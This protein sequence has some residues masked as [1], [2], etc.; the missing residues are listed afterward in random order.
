MLSTD[1]V[2][3]ALTAIGVVVAS[4][5]AYFTFRARPARRELHVVGNFTRVSEPGNGAMGHFELARDLSAANPYSITVRVLNPKAAITS[6]MYDGTV[7][8]KVS[9]HARV[10][11]FE[12]R[13]PTAGVTR[14]TVQIGS[15]D[16][17]LELG[18]GPIRAWQ[19]AMYE[20][21]VDGRPKMEVLSP[22]V[23]VRVHAS[24]RSRQEQ[25]QIIV[26][27]AT[28]LVFMLVAIW[29][30]VTFLASLFG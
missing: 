6:A 5:A 3:L 12:E 4:V 22:F 10:L 15:D 17:S 19:G 18:P 29:L 20:L 16:S 25:R 26:A 2:T 9:F 7:P 13:S 8:L 28:I 14:P 27:G 23:D 1:Q 30:N 11:Y 24:L 21:L